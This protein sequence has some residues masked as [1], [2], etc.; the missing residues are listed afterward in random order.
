MN[1]VDGHDQ[2]IGQLIEGKKMNKYKIIARQVVYE[3]AYVE[4]ESA[5]QAKKLVE[6]GE[7]DPTWDWLDYGEWH[8]ED[9]EECQNA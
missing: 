2:F 1:W 3:F 8:I 7:L 4:A 5:E 6:G 9:V